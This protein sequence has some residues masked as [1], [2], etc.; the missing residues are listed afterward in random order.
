MDS[1]NSHR[2]E[3]AEQQSPKAQSSGCCYCKDSHFGYGRRA[4]VP[5]F[6][7]G[8]FRGGTEVPRALPWA[9]LFGPFRARSE[10]ARLQE[11][12][13]RGKQPSL[14]RR[15]GEL[16]ARPW[17]PLPRVEA[18]SPSLALRVTTTPVRGC[19]AP[20]SVAGH[21]CGANRIRSSVHGSRIWLS[22]AGAAIHTI[23]TDGAC[24]WPGRGAKFNKGQ[25]FP[26]GAAEVESCT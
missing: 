3:R 26:G 18:D 7:G 10:K 24:N 20:R 5:P 1:T 23:G 12:Q 25:T 19:G 13:A 4:P 15:V 17:N 8:R 21:C 2:P 9:L 6:Q 16:A 22:S 11:S 14:K